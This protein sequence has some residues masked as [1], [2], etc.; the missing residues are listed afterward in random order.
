MVVP[1][2]FA[3]ILGEAGAVLKGGKAV[4]RKIPAFAGMTAYLSSESFPRKRESPHQET[5]T[6]NTHA[7][8]ADTR[9]IVPPG[10]TLVSNV[11]T[12]TRLMQLA[13]TPIMNGM[14]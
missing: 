12:I 7:G 1:L 13:A 6:E 2:S 3:G 14:V 8:A 5:L 11:P 4:R 10:L 9:S